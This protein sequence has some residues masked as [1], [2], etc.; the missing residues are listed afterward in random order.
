MSPDK[1]PS[2]RMAECQGLNHI[3][4]D[5]YVLG[6]IDC[7]QDYYSPND[8]TNEALGLLYSLHKAKRKNPRTENGKP[9]YIALLCGYCGEIISTRGSSNSA[10]CIK[11]GQKNT[12]DNTC[13][14]LVRTDDM[15]ELQSTIKREKIKSHSNNKSSQ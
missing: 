7:S 5:L 9:K 1:S 8:V 13:E 11:C 3:L 6:I 10:T 12:I 14:V 2:A 4:T 15:V